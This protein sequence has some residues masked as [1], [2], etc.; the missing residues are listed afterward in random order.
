MTNRIPV[1]FLTL[2]C[3]TTN[4]HCRT[5][6]RC[7]N[8]MKSSQHRVMRMP[9][10]CMLWLR[11]GVFLRIPFPVPT[12]NCRISWITYGRILPQD[13][14]STSKST[15]LPAPFTPPNTTGISLPGVSSA[16]GTAF[17]VTGRAFS[18]LTFVA[19]SLK[20]PNGRRAR[21]WLRLR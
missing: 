21:S 19:D 8:D 12:A 1:P 2:L 5:I 18:S 14:M 15:V 17:A 3:W 10:Q 4:A 16:C 6:W 7:S 11:S 9:P 13:T 20:W